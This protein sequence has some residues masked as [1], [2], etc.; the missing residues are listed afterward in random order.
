[1]IPW[2]DC[3]RPPRRWQAE[4]LP[5]IG[6]AL[7][8]GIRPIV[9][10]ATG[11]GK[12]QLISE[13]CALLARP[14]EVVVVVAPRQSLVEQLSGL[15]G[16]PDIR[17]GSIAWRIGVARVGVYYGRRK[18][19][20]GR[21]VIVTCTPSMAG[22][23]VELAAAG[24]KV[25]T[26][27]VDEAHRSECKAM[28][29]AVEAM[30]PKYTI[31]FTATPWRSD[32]CEALSLF[33]REVYTYGIG[34]AIGEGTLVG[35]DTIGWDV[36]GKGDPGADVACAE[37]IREHGIGPGIVS[38]SSIADAE[39][40]AIYLTEAGIPASAI[41][42]DMPTTERRARIARLLTGDLRCLVHVALMSEGTDIPE[43][44]WICMRRHSATAIRFVQELGRV[45]RTHPGKGRAILLDPFDH[46]GEIG[47]DH[48]S[49]IGEALDRAVE[50][51]V[52]RICVCRGCEGCGVDYDGPEGS[53]ACGAAFRAPEG[54]TSR[55]PL[56]RRKGEAA[57]E[58]MPPLVAV[59][60]V[61]RH[62]RQVMMMLVEAGLVD[63]PLK[64][65]KWRSGYPS[66]KQ[67]ETLRQVGGVEARAV[68]P[69]VDRLNRGEVSD[70]LGYLFAVRRL[71]RSGAALPP[72]P[73][74]PRAAISALESRR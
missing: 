64:G 59:S 8:E 44:R 37:M 74:V 42:S 43:L 38:A 17:A 39:A 48:K 69:H 24:R 52:G 25:R 45:L 65:G 14:G 68:L 33:D 12:A 4:C 15:E 66:P 10:A 55:C 7:R 16:L 21:D 11:S 27:I 23:A 70:L 19:I 72:L 22:L 32:K 58:E 28:I 18:A 5:L 41:H 67:V 71:R 63:E 57:E 29:G 40:Y 34:A 35:W 20:E 54:T 51:E 62:A 49:A 13:M 56:C 47:I 1:M 60:E 61:T 53:S 2:E 30:A 3:P 50:T 26:L 9:R 31:G 73:D 6:T 46:E 36:D